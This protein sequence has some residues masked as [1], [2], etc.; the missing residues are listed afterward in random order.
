PKTPL[1]VQNSQMMDY[2]QVAAEFLRALRGKRSQTA[3]CRRLGYKSNV[4][5]T[6]EACRGFP[7][8]ARTF[9]V[10][11][12]MGVDLQASLTRFYRIAPSWLS[13][14]NLTAPE[15]VAAFV[16]DLRGS[17][18]IVDLAKHMHKSRF[19]V[20]RWVKGE[21]EPKLPDF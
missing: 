19:T 11:E 6:W 7:T 14:V 13:H 12:R 8:A 2:E 5:Y 10:A 4:A 18:S 3:F 16:N 21:T 17:T 9:E 15:G 20:S 1:H